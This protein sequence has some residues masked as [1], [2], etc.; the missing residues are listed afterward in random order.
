MPFV[1][2]NLINF[3]SIA[4]QVFC[5]LLDYPRITFLCDDWT[6]YY[7]VHFH[8]FCSPS[9]G[10][11][12]FSSIFVPSISTTNM[13]TSSFIFVYLSHMKTISSTYWEDL[14]VFLFII[15]LLVIVMERGSLKLVAPLALLFPV[16]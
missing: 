11:L 2:T 9:Y 4:F 7:V 16:D 8:S 13:V 15:I 1:L 6:C 12:I 5:F 3:I 10:F 14:F